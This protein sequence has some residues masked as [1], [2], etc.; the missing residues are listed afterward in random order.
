MK[1]FLLILSSL[2]S[3]LFFLVGCQNPKPQ[4][5][6]ESN[7]LHLN[8]IRWG[9]EDLEALSKMMVQNIL[10]SNN[11]FLKEENIYGFE[12]IRNDS[13]DQIDVKVLK[14]K[15]ITALILSKRFHFTNEI[16]K[17]DYLFR[18]KLTSIFKKNSKSKDMFFTFNMT[19]TNAKTAMI[20]WSHDVEVRKVYERSLI[21][22]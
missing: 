13:H 3:S 10:D 4:T 11:T 17:A 20:V 9:A 21:G 7:V 1:K 14:N 16:S 19:L 18:G 8:S 12:E 22:W 5:Y 15:I 6:Q 2:F